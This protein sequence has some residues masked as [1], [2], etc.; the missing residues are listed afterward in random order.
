MSSKETDTS[1]T[2][3]S[4]VNLRNLP[5]DLVRRAKASAAMRGQ[6]LKAFAV[7]ALKVACTHEESDHAAQEALVRPKPAPPA[8]VPGPPATTEP[9]EPTR[10]AAAPTI[11]W[12]TLGG[13]KRMLEEFERT[14]K[15]Q[16]ESAVEW[17]AFVK[18]GY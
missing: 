8:Q 14:R 3:V 4:T 10:E 11:N 16:P 15:R 5:V 18:H 7:E 1:S 17:L 2:E 9:Q 12:L 6:S 13:S